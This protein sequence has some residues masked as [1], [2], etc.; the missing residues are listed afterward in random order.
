MSIDIGSK[1]V[2][3]PSKTIELD[4]SKKDVALLFIIVSVINNCFLNYHGVLNQAVISN[5]IYIMFHIENDK[6]PVDK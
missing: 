3:V 2:S 4:F 5:M 6:F 1:A